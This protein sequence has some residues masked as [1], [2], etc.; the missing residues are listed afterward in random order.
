MQRAPAAGLSLGR[1]PM[2]PGPGVP[3]GTSQGPFRRCSQQLR[4]GGAGGAAKQHRNTA[5]SD[6]L[7]MFHPVVK[8]GGITARSSRAGHRAVSLLSPLLAPAWVLRG[9]RLPWDV[10]DPRCHAEPM[11]RA[12]GGSEEPS[13]GWREPKV[14][15]PAKVWGVQ[16]GTP[17][18]RRKEH[19]GVPGPGL[20]ALTPVVLV[21]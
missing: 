12:D 19:P 10:A 5:L 16:Q 13:G 9:A 3:G 17:A 20:G 1:V 4:Q 7:H 11:G 6:S 21:T 14:L 8:D 15:L 2:A 18:R